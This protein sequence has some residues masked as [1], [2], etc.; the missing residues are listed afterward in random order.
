[1]LNKNAD[2]LLLMWQK[3]L[4]MHCGISQR[5]FLGLA[6]VAAVLGGGILFILIR[7]STFHARFDKITEKMPALLLSAELEQEARVLVSHTQDIA[8]SRENYQFE[9]ARE[10]IE[11]SVERITQI[12]SKIDPGK[13]ANVH[14]QMLASQYRRFAD[15]QLE[16]LDLKEE[17]LQ[18]KQQ[19]QRIHKRVS[20]LLKELSEENISSHQQV[21][22]VDIATL[23]IWYASIYHAISHL[24]AS[25]TSPYL[26]DIESYAWTLENDLDQAQ[27]AFQGLPT[28]LQDKL[29]KYQVEIQTYAVGEKSLCTFC[30]AKVQIQSRI[31]ECLSKGRSYAAVLLASSHQMHTEAEKIT[32]GEEQ[33]TVQELGKFHLYLSLL[34]VM[35]LASLAGIYIFVRRSVI[36]R[37]LSI[38]HDLISYNLDDTKERHCIEEKGDDELTS[39][40]AGINY[41][42]EQIQQREQRLRTAA[43]DAEL[44]SEAKSA[45]VAAISHEI[46]TP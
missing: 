43:Q 11:Q 35:V 16:L 37:I 32:L 46:R 7:F 31:D 3:S 30:S 1:L 15:N 21:A 33:R 20:T 36:S 9:D 45:F 38:H 8:I 41:F 13:D 12:T 5:I 18:I 10:L 14:L 29:N 44:A 34:A 27:K 40:A 2:I 39:L 24:L 42:L 26:E 28:E 22:A 23:N 25:Y 19:Q 4:S 6:L 17:T